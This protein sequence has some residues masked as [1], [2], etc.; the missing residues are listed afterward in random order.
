MMTQHG[1]T[2]EESELGEREEEQDALRE[3][4]RL[5]T[6][7]PATGQLRVEGEEGTDRQTTEGASSPSRRVVYPREKKSIFKRHSRRKI[8]VLDA[9]KLSPRHH[10]D[11][12]SEKSPKLS[13]KHHPDNVSEKS[14]D[15]SESPNPEERKEKERSKR[16]KKLKSFRKVA[17][18]VKIGRKL[19][20]KGSSS[21]DGD[22]SP[23]EVG[24]GEDGEAVEEGVDERDDTTSRREEGGGDGQKNTETAFPGMKADQE[25]AP[26]RPESLGTQLM[27]HKSSGINFK[28]TSMSFRQPEKRNS[29][30]IT[31]SETHSKKSNQRN[32]ERRI[33]APSNFRL[34]PGTP[35]TSG[36][37]LTTDPPSDSP[38]TPIV[39]ISTPSAVS[40]SVFATEEEVFAVQGIKCCKWG[41]WMCVS[42]A[43]GHVMAFSF[44]MDESVT[45]PK[46]RC[47]LYA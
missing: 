20:S 6:P 7:S 37:I 42:N 26:Q 9:P 44:Q 45:T 23:S 19:L 39:E 24:E 40:D 5:K 14:D 10:P 29:S 15:R 38:L 3:L 1:R 47:T 32:F 31:P 33:S 16:S 27:Y 17:I 21:E 4:E 30:V 34:S 8:N 36:K 25:G 41:Q 12:V 13:P 28:K 43:G 46:V 22:V 2:S 35:A 18:K 11:N